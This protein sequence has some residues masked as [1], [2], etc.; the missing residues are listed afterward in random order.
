MGLSER[1]LDEVVR[2][3]HAEVSD[4]R[5][6]RLRADAEA[7]RPSMDGEDLRQLTQALLGG[8]FDRLARERL[9]QGLE[10]IDA[11]D[12]R[13]VIAAVQSM[14]R[15]GWVI[16]ELMADPEV[17][18]IDINGPET[19]FVTRADGTKTRLG[20]AIAR[21]NDELERWVRNAAARLGL[22]E[23]R[24]DE[25]RPHLILRLPDGSRLFACMSV[26]AD[27]HISIRIHRHPRVEL[28]DLVEAGMMSVELGAFL[29]AL[30]LA[31]ANIVVSGPT[32]AGKTTLIRALLNE[33][34]PQERIITVE[35][36]YELGLDR[37]RDRHPD[38]VALEAREANVEGVGEIT[39]AD[40]VRHSLR[41]NPTRVTVGEVRGDEVIPMLQVMTQGESG[42]MCTIHSDSSAGV[43]QRLAVF[44]I[45]APEHLEPRHTGLLVAQ[46]VDF[47][48]H[49]SHERAGGSQR[50]YVSSVREVTG[51][52]EKGIETNEVFALDATG[53]AVATGA[54]PVSERFRERLAQVGWTPGASAGA[55]RPVR[56]NGRRSPR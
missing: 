31:G 34:P 49:I 56:A 42:S 20:Y 46:A 36:S 41:M 10:P 16:E 47:I 43:F 17:E 30:V 53:M 29:G 5:A 27:V 26:T 1:D 11:G 9:G 38:V 2:R 37:L 18:N 21:S 15:L 52:H 24:F 22:S 33:V 44:A 25:G 8:F 14:G 55:L 12:E 48:V 28:A 3:A 54:H 45:C 23:R 50:R 6:V 51:D 40:L 13:R 32:N 4:A 7:G 35:D 39:M 19:A